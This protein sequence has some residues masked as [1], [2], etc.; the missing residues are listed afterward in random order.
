VT[1]VG[2]YFVV[3]ATVVVGTIAVLVLGW[4]TAEVVFVDVA[5]DAEMYHAYHGFEQVVLN[6]TTHKI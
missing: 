5:A 1:V 6:E 3:S 4:V 2:R